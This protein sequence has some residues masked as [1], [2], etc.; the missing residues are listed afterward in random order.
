MYVAP[1][2]QQQPLQQHW[3][4]LPSPPQLQQATHG[5]GGISPFPPA[6]QGAPDHAF[7]A[8]PGPPPFGAPH[9]F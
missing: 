6:G 7:R 2:P 4:Y 8:F 1:P 5:P 9:H 3:A